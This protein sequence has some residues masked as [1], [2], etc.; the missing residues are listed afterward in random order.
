MLSS[1]SLLRIAVP[2]RP[3]GV[4]E[5]EEVTG[6]EVRES[7]QQEAADRDAQQGVDDAEDLAA[8]RLRRYMPV[9]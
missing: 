9:A 2:F 8:G 6:E 4:V 1:S 3:F 7:G 5:V